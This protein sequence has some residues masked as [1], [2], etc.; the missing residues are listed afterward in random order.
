MLQFIVACL[1]DISALRTGAV[2]D[3]TTTENLVSFRLLHAFW[4]PIGAFF[5]TMRGELFR[6]LT[7]LRHV[8]V[9]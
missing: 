3:V 2:S 7:F 4:V 8:D 1:T 9:L 6:A 5:V